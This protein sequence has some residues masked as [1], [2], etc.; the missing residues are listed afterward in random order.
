MNAVVAVAAV[1]ATAKHQMR[2]FFGFR[3]TTTARSTYGSK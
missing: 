2:S 3:G 1:T